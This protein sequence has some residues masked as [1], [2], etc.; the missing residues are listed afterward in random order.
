MV[1]VKASAAGSRVERPIVNT[2]VTMA[3]IEFNLRVGVAD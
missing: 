1:A 2:T 3:A